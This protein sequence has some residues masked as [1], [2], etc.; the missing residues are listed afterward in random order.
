VLAAR[1][2]GPLQ[3]VVDLVRGLP[4]QEEPADEQ[5]QVTPE[6]PWLKRVKSGRVRRTI[7]AIEK[8]SSMRLTNA[9]ASPSFRPSACCATGSFPRG[10]R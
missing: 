1:V 2:V 8:R 9:I 10:S 3:L 6:T 7:Q 5:D 4:D